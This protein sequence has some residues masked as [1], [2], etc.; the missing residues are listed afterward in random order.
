MDWALENGQGSVQMRG[1]LRA[2]LNRFE[3]RLSILSAIEL[4]EDTENN[5]VIFFISGGV[6]GNFGTES[7]EIETKLS[8][9]DQYAEEPS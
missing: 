6:Q 2:R 8:R 4:Y 5:T 3:M 7:I 1:M 9:M